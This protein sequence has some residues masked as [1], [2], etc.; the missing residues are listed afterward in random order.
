MEWYVFA[1]LAPAFWAMNN[2]FMKFLITNKFKSYFSLIFAVVCIDAIFALMVP[3]FTVVSL[4]VPNSI[5]GF[6]AGLLPMFAFW[7]YSKALMTEEVTRIATLFQLIPVFVVLLSVVFLNEILGPQRYLGIG[8]IVFASMLISY[9]KGKGQFF[10]KALKFMIPFSIIIA[11]YTIVDKILL[12]Y[13]DYW[14][15]FFWNIL[16]TFCGVIFMLLFPKIR[17]EV[18]DTFKKAG[19]K[20]FITTLI[21]ESLYVVGTL[22]SLISLSLIDAS[23]ASSLFGLQPFFV[24]F[25]MLTISLFFSHILKEELGK[26]VILFKIF[27]ISL[28]LIGTWLVI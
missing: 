13:L 12:G 18:I 11:T 26:T 20:T 10:S 23:L 21:G 27:S 25:Y 28:M 6:L 22:C 16:G 19:T 24:F 5:M 7:F 2:V 9:K 14:S 1:L 4:N 3:L 8:L 15:L 17:N